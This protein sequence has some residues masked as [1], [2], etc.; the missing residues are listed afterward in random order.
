VFVPVRASTVP[1][2][3]VPVGV[4]G[5]QFVQGQVP[6]G[7]DLAN[8]LGGFGD[9]GAGVDVHDGI[10]A[11]AEQVCQDH[12]VV[13]AGEQREQRFHRI[14]GQHPVHDHV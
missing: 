12:R 3:Q 7:G 8:V 9:A 10:G 5:V 11:V 6:G 4:A 13:A 1:E 2:H 14:G